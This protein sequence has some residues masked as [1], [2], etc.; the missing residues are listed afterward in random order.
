MFFL[1]PRPVHS[2]AHS[3]LFYVRIPDWSL[4]LSTSFL[5]INGLKSANIA[6]A[7][8]PSLTC[9]KPLKRP[10]IL[11]CDVIKTVA[12]RVI[13][14]Y[15]PLVNIHVCRCLSHNIS[16]F[17][18]PPTRKGI[19]LMS[20]ST[21]KINNCKLLCSCKAYDSP[22]ISWGHVFRS[23]LRCSRLEPRC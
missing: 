22:D 14:H 5:D 18:G 7:N 13:G 23:D 6:S 10:G 8:A 4:T 3:Q 20:A 1:A 2:K 21:I 9:Q 17:A 16:A 19:T 12:C 11:P 15:T